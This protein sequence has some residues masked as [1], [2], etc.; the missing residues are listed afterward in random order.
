MCGALLPGLA[1]F[2]LQWWNLAI[3]QLTYYSYTRI[4]VCMLV[5]ALATC[6]EAVNA[7]SGI[8]DSARSGIADSM[9]RRA[10]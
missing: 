7:C 1:K 5:Y 4:L 3:R 8:D 6:F 9:M 10:L 2:L